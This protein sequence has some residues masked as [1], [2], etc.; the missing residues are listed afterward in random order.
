ML[1]NVFGDRTM[2]PK[3]VNN[4]KVEKRVEDKD[5][6]KL[7]STSTHKQRVAEELILHNNSSTIKSFTG[8]VNISFG[9]LGSRKVEKW[10][11]FG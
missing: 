6:L 10:F 7:P 2:P 11:F 4:K 5:C 9:A 3:N 1:Q 8:I